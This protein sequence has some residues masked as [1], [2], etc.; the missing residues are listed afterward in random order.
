MINIFFGNYKT[1]KISNTK[2]LTT[3]TFNA[4]SDIFVFHKLF[5]YYMQLAIW[6]STFS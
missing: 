6:I 3:S 1:F 4:I 5:F 2:E